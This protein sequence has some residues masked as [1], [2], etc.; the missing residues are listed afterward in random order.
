VVAT[1]RRRALL[2]STLEELLAATAPAEVVVVDD[3][4]GDGTAE[5]LAERAAAE[6][7]LRPVIQGNAGEMA[8]RLAGARAATGDVVL[9]LD[10][11]VIPAPGIVEGHARHHA[12]AT[13]LVVVGY[14]PVPPARPARTSYPRDIY[15]RAYEAHTAAWE[16]H[17]DR[18]L[19]VLW[20]GHLSLRRD[21]FL[22]LGAALPAEALPYHADLDFG[23]ACER[24]GLRGVFDRRL[25]SRHLYERSVDAYAADA[26]KS[27]HGTRD[28]HRRHPDVLGPLPGDFATAGLPRPAAWL[29]R[30][31]ATAAWPRALAGAL[32]ATAGALRLWRLQRFAAAALLWR[33]EQQRAV[34]SSP[35]SAAAP[36]PS[37]PTEESLR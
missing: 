1:Y 11:D 5:L 25:A 9:L 28:A 33:M 13:D 32:V 35:P 7:R 17:P 36:V 22:A 31:S 21:A 2:E 24:A 10:D 30:R 23:I 20:A 19:R 34:A 37:R 29:V 14:M 27:G 4:S 8:A 26:A 16:A 12:T 6:P 3:G 15:A 18:V